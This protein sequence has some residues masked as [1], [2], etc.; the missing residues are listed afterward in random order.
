MKTRWQVI[1]LIVLAVVLGAVSLE[2]QLS[3]P[4]KPAILIPNLRNTDWTGSGTIMKFDPSNTNFQVPQWGEYSMRI[5]IMMQDRHV[6]GGIIVN[7]NCPGDVV[8]LGGRVTGYVSSS[9]HVSMSLYV[10]CICS[11]NTGGG[12]TYLGDTPPTHQFT[13]QLSNDKTV[14]AG[15]MH[16]LAA[17]DLPT[18]SITFE[19]D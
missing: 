17:N 14:M 5:L 10:G 3:F 8:N 6:F 2:A 19:K 16:S 12:L 18:I 11:E 15:Y 1:G 4:H 13:G 7:D 9:G